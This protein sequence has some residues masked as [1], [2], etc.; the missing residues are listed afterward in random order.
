[1][2]LMAINAVA[3]KNIADAIHGSEC[4]FIHISSDYVYDGK[5]CVPYNEDSPVK[6]TVSIWQVKACR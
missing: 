5:A 6:S 3:V 4:R 2:Q 1:M